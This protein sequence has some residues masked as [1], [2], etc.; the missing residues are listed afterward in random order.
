MHVE[1]N[2]TVRPLSRYQWLMPPEIGLG[3]DRRPEIKEEKIIR[4]FK[5]IRET[6]SELF[7]STKKGKK[8]MFNFFRG[9]YTYDTFLS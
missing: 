2:A 4:F 7:I 8:L 1:I 9:P 6:I 3:A 5:K